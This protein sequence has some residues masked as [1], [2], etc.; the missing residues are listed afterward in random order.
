MDSFPAL[1]IDKS[2]LISQNNRVNVDKWSI[3]PASI[4]KTINGFYSKYRFIVKRLNIRYSAGK[5]PSNRIK[6]QRIDRIF[7]L[8][9][10][11]NVHEC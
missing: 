8:K 3:A 10:G 6:L 5:Y 7:Q 4:D 11:G 9:I 1:N 2:I